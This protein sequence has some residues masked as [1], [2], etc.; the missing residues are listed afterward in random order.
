MAQKF[1]NGRWVKE[2]FLDNRM[3]GIVTGQIVFAAVGSIDF[4]LA[5][6]FKPDLAGRLIRFR[7]AKFEEDD[8]AAQVIG[9]MENP[10]LGSVNL[11]SFDPHP[12]L[13]PH[14]YIEWFSAG[15]QHYRFELLPGEAWVV[16]EGDIDELN[17]ESLRIRSSYGGR[18]AQRPPSEDEPEWM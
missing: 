16:S 6:N 4:L 1:G 10:Q 13:A 12:N 8:L 15:K 3:E 5:G 9:D 18:P 11:I 2:G 17:Q 7:N 14:P